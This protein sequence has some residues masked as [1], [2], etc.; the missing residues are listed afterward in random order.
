MTGI[1][2]VCL[3]FCC[4][5]FFENFLSVNVA[6]LIILAGFVVVLSV[7]FLRSR[8]LFY[9]M[10]YFL[11]FLCG[12]LAY[13]QAYYLPKDSVASLEALLK[14][15]IV[16]C[17]VIE[18][19]PQ[20]YAN[21]TSFVLN[22][23]YV[24][25]LSEKSFVRARVLVEDRQM[26]DYCFGSELVLKGILS[27][28][29]RILFSGKK[30]GYTQFLE[31]RGIYYVFK[32][33]K[34]GLLANQPAKK[35][36]FI[37]AAAFSV[38][39]RAR[40]LI[41]RNLKPPC[42]SILCAMLLGQRAGVPNHVRKTMMKIGVWHV[43]VVSGLHVALIAAMMLLVLKVFRFSFKSRV[44]LTMAFLWFYCFLA[45]CSISI[46]RA[47]MMTSIFLV[48]SL[49]ERKPHFYNTFSLT[50][51]IILVVNPLQLLDIGFQLSFLSVFFIIWLSPKF[52]RVFSSL[53]FTNRFIGRLKQYFCVALSAWLGTLP[54][55]AYYFSNFSWLAVF[56]NVIIVP[57]STL[58]V[59]SG[60]VLVIAE[61]VCPPAA[62]LIAQAN[63]FFIFVFLKTATFLSG[64]PFGYVK[65]IHVSLAVV[66]G[67]Y[68]MILFLGLLLN[69]VEKILLRKKSLL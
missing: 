49:L 61:A 57:L 62:C 59:A 15:D 31:R 36:N 52:E 65:N 39:H 17:G 50:A 47:V 35:K 11:V 2:M 53:I 12:A 21:R 40:S 63:T 26:R 44:C 41:A 16:I 60:L 54:I 48:S 67:C 29:P 43:L 6:A 20:L 32:V 19:D 13:A 56:A 23:V 1:A 58:I 64:L 28:P 25:S 46:V 7:L 4:G 42:A 5:I 9:V 30:S 18:T 45:G 38:K 3:I 24:Q 10:F 27:K 33:S 37:K 14:E 66:L 34:D 8:R 69:Y 22:T 51:L 68:S 55:I